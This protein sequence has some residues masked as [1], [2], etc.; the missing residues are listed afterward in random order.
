MRDTGLGGAG[1]GR[2]CHLQ[3]NILVTISEDFV[4][5]GCKVG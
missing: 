4:I 3:V 1:C 5:I 2:C